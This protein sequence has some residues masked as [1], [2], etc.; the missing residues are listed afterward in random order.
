MSEKPNK[1]VPETGGRY[2]LKDKKQIDPKAYRADKID[3]IFKQEAM[4][5]RIT[6]A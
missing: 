3:A 2:A 1:V 6:S 5:R 4:K